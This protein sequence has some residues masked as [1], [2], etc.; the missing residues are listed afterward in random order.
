LL[1]LEQQELNGGESFTLASVPRQANARSSLGQFDHSLDKRDGVRRAALVQ[2]REAN[3]PIVDPAAI[4]LLLARRGGQTAPSS[5]GTL[6]AQSLRDA[7]RATSSM[8]MC[9]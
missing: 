6:P 9:A 8:K 1:Q 3:R 2:K 7:P 4:Q 5:S